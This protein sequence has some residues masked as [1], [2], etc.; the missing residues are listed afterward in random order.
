VQRV[1]KNTKSIKIF[2]NSRL[3]LTLLALHSG[4]YRINGGFGF[5]ITEPRCELTF[6]KNAVFNIYDN[7]KISFDQND[8]NNLC[9]ILQSEQNKNNFPNALDIYVEGNMRQHSGFGS[10]T[11]TTL[12]CLEALHLLNGSYP[13]PDDL[14]YASGR[15]GTS[16]IGIH[17][18][19]TGGYVFDLGRPIINK[20]TPIPSHQAKEK[21]KPLL[22]DNR[23]MPDWNIGVCLPLN[24]PLKSQSEEREFFARTCP[25][26]PDAAYKTV[27]HTLFGLY[28]SLREG[29]RY[30]FCRA[31]KE[32]QTCAWK[33]AERLEYGEELVFMEKMLYI[34]GAD[35]VGMSSLGPCLFF[36]AEDVSS[37]IEKMQPEY[38]NCQWFITRP[39]NCGRR[40]EV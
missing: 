39:D 3:H 13:E 14:I 19:F 5:A 4:E 35:A 29:D 28:A 6:I 37:I 26:Q 17:S 15:G 10:G 34:N 22:L 27:Y 32:I 33:N 23:P 7:K 2:V 9:A 16:G 21:Q 30:G 31:I 38:T 24:I 40:I 36:L 25:I 12:A 8:I 1:N 11:S 20:E 18:Y